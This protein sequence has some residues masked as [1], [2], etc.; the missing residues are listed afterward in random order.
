MG[1]VKNLLRESGP[2]SSPFMDPSLTLRAAISGGFLFALR[3]AWRRG[4][5]PRREPAVSFPHAKRSAMMSPTGVAAFDNTLLLAEGTRQ[6]AVNVAGV[7]QST[8][9]TGTIAYYRTLLASAV[10]RHRCCQFHWRAGKSWRDGL[11]K[12]EDNYD[13]PYAAAAADCV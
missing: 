10:A 2:S 11:S 6:A 8:V 13:E 1:A 9:N 7:S 12:S 5:L 3:G 4:A